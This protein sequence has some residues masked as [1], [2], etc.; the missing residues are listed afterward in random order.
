MARLWGSLSLFVI[1]AVV[2]HASGSISTNLGM[3][4]V[5]ARASLLAAWQA[6]ARGEASKAARLALLVSTPQVVRVRVVHEGRSGQASLD[7]ILQ[8]ALNEW[9]AAGVSFLVSEAA[10]PEP[11]LTV[12]F[13]D[14]VHG[15][16]GWIAGKTISRRS[17]TVDGA[18]SIRTTIEIATLSPFGGR[19]SDD[20]LLK[21]ILHEVGHFMGLGDVSD[22][23]E[24]M[25]PVVLA[26]S[27]DA[28]LEERH[29]QAV[30]Q[31]NAEAARLARLSPAPVVEDPAY[32]RPVIFIFPS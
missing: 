14:R 24:V 10:Y 31:L 26:G 4:D 16:R 28:R 2:A 29:V 22:P 3:L 19:L 23:R 11:H 13:R 8:D 30:L 25:G 18:L 1:G 6:E 20:A 32:R 12:V 21:T 5:D 17:V 9:E 27:N 7:A 15:R